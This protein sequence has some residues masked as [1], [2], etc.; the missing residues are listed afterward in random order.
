[1]YIADSRVYAEQKECL[2]KLYARIIYSSSSCADFFFWQECYHFSLV[3]FVVFAII[4]DLMS[5]DEI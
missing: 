5:F 3:T 4:S 1:M 2:P